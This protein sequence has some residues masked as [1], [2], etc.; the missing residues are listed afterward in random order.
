[1]LFRSHSAGRAAE[2]A[3]R[4]TAENGEWRLYSG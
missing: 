1:M 3:I 2:N 4:Y